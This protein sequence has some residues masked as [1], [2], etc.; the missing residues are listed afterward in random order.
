MSPSR[1]DAS[2]PAPRQREP[3]SSSLQTLLAQSEATSVT[4]NELMERTGG[5]GLY[6]MMI[7]LSLPFIT[8]LPLPGFSSVLGLVIALLAVRLAFRLPPR[9]PRF[10]GTREI[11][12]RRMRSFVESSAKFLHALERI[13]RPRYSD[14]LEWRTIRF[15]N[16][17]ILVLMG[18]LLALPLPPVLPLTNSM[19]SWAIIMVALAMMEADGVLI[20]TG[21]AI[22]FGTLFYLIFFAGVVAA[23]IG[24]MFGQG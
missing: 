4:L 2:K 12:R 22:A 7:L 20:W 19:P 15:L 6:L 16:A 11:S 3:L 18:L 10:I 17:S 24:R 9:L 8:P 5:R 14:W 21:Y 13:A 23:G 1:S